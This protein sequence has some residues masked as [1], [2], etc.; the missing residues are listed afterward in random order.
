MSAN[1]RQ[2]AILIQA[3]NTMGQS[4][5]AAIRFK[6]L[7]FRVAR[8]S[9]YQDIAYFNQSGSTSNVG[10]YFDGTGN[11]ITTGSG[12]AQVTFNFGWNDQPNQDGQAL[13]NLKS[14]C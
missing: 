7:T 6:I 14:S 4:A 13:G 5:A 12:S 8:Y 9:D 2:G 1:K 11:L 10:M 3:S